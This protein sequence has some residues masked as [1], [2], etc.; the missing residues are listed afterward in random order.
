[1]KT[2]RRF[3]IVS[4][5]TASLFVASSH[6]SLF[7]ADIEDLKSK[8]ADRNSAIE[9][10]EA[11]IAG[12]QADLDKVG[13]QSK[14]LQS[15]ITTINL[16]KKKLET[17]IK[18]TENRVE[19]VNLTIKELSL[20]ISDKSDLISTNIQAMG[21]TVKSLDRMETTSLLV[22]LLKHETLSAL[23]DGIDNLERFE[24]QVQSELHRVREL[25]TG[26]ETQKTATE[27]KQ[28]ELTALRSR[29]SDQKQ[30]LTSNKNEQNRLLSATKN[31]ES[32][33]KKV[34]A[35]KVALRDSFER[36]MLEFESQ[37]KFEIDPTRLPSIGKGVLNWPL[38]KIRLTQEFGDTSFAKSGAYNG[39]G[40]NGVDF[41]ASIGTPVRAALSGVIKGTGDTDTVCRGASYGKWIMIEHGNGLSTL[42]AHLSL[43]K[44]TEGQEIS[45]GQIIGY[46]GNT[47]YSTGPHL[48]FTVYATQG[49]KILDRKSAVCKGTYTMPIADLKAYLDPLEYL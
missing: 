8:I 16:Q 29:L 6:A 32:E 28:R 23:W 17:D 38:D 27:A 35:Q 41:A 18:L 4:A 37:L 19:A 26:L 30:I 25:K 24:V 12:Y 42:Y 1:M 21:E 49:V 2:W 47:G 34:L 11:E 40:H 31:K 15:A 9:A 3:F 48:H 33:Y 46:A 43:I 45:T 5:I 36:E 20:D 39:K 13:K 44:V 14:S 22:I 7:A 10:L